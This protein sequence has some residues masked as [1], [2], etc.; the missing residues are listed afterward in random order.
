[1]LVM[2]SMAG[3]FLATQ[4]TDGCAKFQR[5]ADDLFI[6]ARPARC[7][8]ASHIANIG[9][10]E[11]KPDALPQVCDIRFGYTRIGARGADLST[12][13]TFLDA[14]DQCI[15]GAA[16]HVGVGADHF[17]GLHGISSRTSAQKN[18]LPQFR[19]VSAECV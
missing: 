15:I 9:A 3:T 11:V 1:M 13:V 8:A 5:P 17:M 2:G 16:S 4:P 19:I 12:G 14:A 6:G 10:I 7:H 18:Q